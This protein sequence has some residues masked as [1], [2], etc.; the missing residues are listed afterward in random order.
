MYRAAGVVYC[1]GCSKQQDS[2]QFTF[3]TPTKGEMRKKILESET[4]Q[5]LLD[6]FK[7]HNDAVK[8]CASRALIALSGGI[9]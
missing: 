7:S 5:R 3:L 2:I 6:L 9:Y 8:Y 4:T 1:A